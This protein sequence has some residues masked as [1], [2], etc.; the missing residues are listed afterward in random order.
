MY[1]SA[2]QTDGICNLQHSFN[3]KHETLSLK[4]HSLKQCYMYIHIQYI[5]R[6]TV[7]TVLT[8]STFCACSIQPKVTTW[9]FFF[10]S[11]VFFLF[12]SLF[13]IS[14]WER[15]EEWAQNAYC[16][17]F[18]VFVIIAKMGYVLFSHRIFIM[19]I[20]CHSLTNGWKSFCT[21]E[22]CV[23]IYNEI[24]HNENFVSRL[25]WFVIGNSIFFRAANDYT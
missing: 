3:L 14:I 11:L 21:H 20:H 15:S 7:W 17:F 10:L 18:F 24:W 23:H 25:C 8:L 5:H 4:G 19:I 9:T 16:V 22:I 6:E 1:S 12:L 13:S 2:F